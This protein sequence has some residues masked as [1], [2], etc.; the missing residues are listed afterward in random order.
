MLFRKGQQPMLF[1]QSDD[2]IMS[3]SSDNVKNG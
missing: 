2:K 3:M 1:K